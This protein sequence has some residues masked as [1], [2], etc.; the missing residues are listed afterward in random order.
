MRFGKLWW[1]FGLLGLAS[2]RTTDAE[3]TFLEECAPTFNFTGAVLA[4]DGWTPKTEVRLVFNY[5]PN[6][7]HYAAV[8]TAEGARFLKVQG[9]QEAPLGGSFAFQPG[10]E[11][12]ITLQR[13]EW[14]MA[15]IAEGQVVAR[16][17]DETFHGGQLG[18]ATTGG[19]RVDDPRQQPTEEIFWADDFARGEGDTWEPLL[20]QWKLSGVKG[21]RPEPNKSANP[22]SLSTQQPEGLSLTT[23]GYWF[24]DNYVFQAAVRPEGLGAVG[25]CAYLQDANNYL[26]FRW[27]ARGGQEKQVVRVRAGEETVLAQADGGFTPGQWYALSFAV[28]EGYLTAKID[29]QVVLEAV[30]DSFGQGRVGFYVRDCD[31][32][33][34][35]DALVEEAPDFS[36]DFRFRSVGKWEDVGA[37]WQTRNAELRGGEPGPD[38]RRKMEAATGLTLTGSAEWRDYTVSAQVEPG[39]AH[40]VGLCWAYRDP[41]NYYLFRWGGDQAPASYRRKQQLVRIADGAETVLAERDVAEGP[42]PARLAVRTEGGFLQASVGGQTVLEAF[43]GNATRGRVGCLSEGGPGTRISQVRVYFPMPETGPKLTEQFTREA[44]MAGWASPAGEWW[45]EKQGQFWHRGEF[46]GDTSLSVALP[47]GRQHGDGLVLTLHASQPTPQSGYSLHLVSPA[48]GQV[49]GTLLRD[50]QI[51]AENQLLCEPT[52]E[53]ELEFRRQGRLLV[54][55]VNG[56]PLVNFRDDQ[57]LPGRLVGVLLGRSGVELERVRVRSSHL[58]DETFSAAPT[59]WWASKGLWEGTARWSC[60]PGWTWFGGSG[61]EAPVLWSKPAFAGDF[62]VEGYVAL[63]MSG[64]GLGGYPNPRDLNLTICGDGQN[65]NSG[66]SFIFAGWGNQRTA[67]LRRDQVVQETTDQRFLLRNPSPANVNFHRH[68]FHLRVQKTGPRL[69]CYVDDELAL[70]YE[71]PDPLPGGRVAF[72]TWNN[73]LLVA[74][75]RVWYEALTAGGPLLAPPPDRLLAPPTAA[76]KPEASIL[77]ADFEDGFDGWSD[78]GEVYGPILSLDDSTA[79]EGRQS[80]KITN[81]TSGGTFAVWTGAVEVDVREHPR[82]RFDYK[83]PPEVKVNLYFKLGRQTW[84]EI[85]FTDPGQPAERVKTLGHIP[86]VVADNEWR[87]AEFDLLTALQQQGL[88]DVPLLI[89]QLSFASRQDPYLRCGFGGNPAGA[90]FHLDNFALE[91]PAQGEV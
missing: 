31:R 66:Y 46:F 77:Q 26:L 68:W 78:H 9:G 36:E 6:G 51:V 73:G 61:Q 82:L 62:T 47:S 25:L 29:G 72:W 43:D 48:A 8:L 71:D 65:L 21:V 20:G 11:T 32:A 75:A 87:H 70:E 57:P 80:L 27:A 7:D 14:P 86:N 90:T 50:G 38:Y 58:L 19:V 53:T 63:Q 3:P 35:D 24:W 67:L 83:V 45:P 69:R 30:D 13:R 41:A 37:A 1:L 52:E 40:G 22:F 54:A 84:Y 60:S 76:E 89:R 18:L 74:R 16:A 91:G 10:P 33:T 15:L 12:A 44:T 34:F 79:S 85:V 17:Y 39:Q 64:R 81:A 2:F 28:R 5:Q 56:T 49:Q 88:D 55:R 4:P 59:N 23:T 42:T